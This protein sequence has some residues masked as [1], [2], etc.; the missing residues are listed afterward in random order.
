[1]G[2][3]FKY[4]LQPLL[5]QKIDHKDNAARE[6][7]ARQADLQRAI[8]RLEELRR[9]EEAVVLKRRNAR[10][11]IVPEGG[12]NGIELGNRADFLRALDMDL[13][14]AKQ[15]VFSQ[16]IVIEDEEELVTRARG[17]L[18]ECSREV[19]ILTKHRE[20]AAGR[21]RLELEQKEAL[22]QEEIGALLHEAH[23]RRT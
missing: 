7:A 5:D 21:F 12:A 4:R 20:K 8:Q 16:R 23:R 22:E 18:A 9:Q 17:V 19:E 10:L 15:S 6:L 13:D 14:D 1:M 2:T 3:V 11:G